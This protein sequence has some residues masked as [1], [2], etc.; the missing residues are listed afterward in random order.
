MPF[1]IRIK[2][3]KSSSFEE[4][5]PQCTL[6]PPAGHKGGEVA[7]DMSSKRRAIKTT[8]IHSRNTVSALEMP[9]EQAEQV[10]GVDSTLQE[11][12]TRTPN[13]KLVDE[14]VSLLKVC[15]FWNWCRS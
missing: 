1:K 2:S 13:A 10:V 15:N 6:P 14:F 4:G 11:I 3:V 9:P 5:T 8:P 12:K 7:G